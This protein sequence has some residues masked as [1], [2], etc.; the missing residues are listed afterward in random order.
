MKTAVRTSAPRRVAGFMTDS[1]LL[2]IRARNFEH[3]EAFYWLI[4][5][6]WRRWRRVIYLRDAM[7]KPR[8]LSKGSG[9]YHVVPA[10]VSITIIKPRAGKVNESSCATAAEHHSAYRVVANNSE[11]H[12][13][14]VAC[15]DNARYFR[16]MR[17][18]NSNENADALHIERVC[19]VRLHAQRDRVP[20]PGRRSKGDLTS[21]PG[22]V[23]VT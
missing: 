6:G 12:C 2:V 1:S 19:I 10:P 11:M 22:Y 3:R 4:K 16:S 8:T 20:V 15:N 17:N 21:C 9:F 14:R 13:I 7:C 18:R 5:N 23:D